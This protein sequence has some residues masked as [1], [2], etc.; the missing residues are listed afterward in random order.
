MRLTSFQYLLVF[1]TSLLLCGLLTPLMKNLAIKF[2][3]VDKPNQA[4]KTH[5]G[6]VPYLGGLAIMATIW[7][8]TLC[9]SL[10]IQIG[11]STFEILLSILL[12]AT[13]LG[14]IGLWDDIKN[15]SPL[16]R[17][18][19]QTLG[20]CF[21][22]GFIVSTNTIGL[23][24]GNDIQD[25][26]ITVFWIVGITN[27]VN[28]FDNLDGGASGSVTIS[29]LGLFALA[30]IS[31]QFYVATL[32]LVLAGSAFGFLFWNRNPAKIYMGDAGALF[33]GMLLATLLVRFE[34]NLINSYA[35]Y[36]IPVM[37]VALP[38]L[39]T[40]VALS[41][42]LR[43]GKSLFQGGTDHLSHRLLRR[44]FTS[45]RCALILWLLTLVFV[46]LAILISNVSYKYESII[47]LTSLILWAFLYFKFMEQ[48]DE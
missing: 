36:A 10:L 38:I 1:I 42:R 16:P 25:F 48:S 24:T 11:R 19:A 34:P 40:S 23:P 39:D 43:R 3:I 33:L 2:S 13:L 8:V 6:S 5:F 45:T 22:A 44:G 12:P 41:S 15:L 26:V 21:T 47:L 7:S 31:G 29:S 9:G 17:F 14:L 32:S 37:I 18:V 20:G 4:H 30:L 35:G 27:A 28:F 46:L